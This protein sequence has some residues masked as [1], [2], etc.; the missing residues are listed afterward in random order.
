MLYQFKRKILPLLIIFVMLFSSMGAALADYET[1]GR[2]LVVTENGITY[3]IQG[4]YS[5]NRTK[6]SISTAQDKDY[7]EISIS[8]NN[9]TVVSTTYD[10]K[11][12]NFLGTP[13]YSESRQVIDLDTFDSQSIDSLTLQAITYN[14]TTKTPSDFGDRYDYAYGSEGAKTYLKIHCKNT[15]QIRTD[16]LSDAKEAKC[17][18]YTSSIK[19]CNSSMAKYRVGT[20]GSG[21]ATGVL[22][23]LI[24]V[25]IAFPPSVIVTII[26]A[27]VGAAT[28]Y[29]AAI[30]CLIDSYEY[31]RD[32]KDLYVTIRSYGT[33][34][35]PGHF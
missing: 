3:F 8:K 15:Y 29:T 12:K 21:I 32:A 30:Y 20:V 23:G 17:D 14:S 9:G 16:T 22:V 28:G 18:A 27:A 34:I 5:K 6:V 7:T 31:Y 1:L 10:Y 11:G 33:N 4:S 24:I 13:R 2:K 26:V 19:K 25:N 35:T